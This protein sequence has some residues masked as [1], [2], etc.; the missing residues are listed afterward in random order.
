MDLVAVAAMTQDRI[1]AKD[2][3]L[4]WDHPADVEQYKRRV[5]NAPVVVGRKTFEDMYPDPPGAR[6]IVLTRSGTDA[7]LASTTVVGDVPGAL[8]VARDFGTD[9]TY[10]V[11]GG[12]VYVLFYPHYD[13]MVLTV[14]KDV[15]EATGAE[16]TRFPEWDRSKWVRYDRDESYS[17]LHIDFWR[18]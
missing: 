11:G 3:E 14:V 5:S 17:G 7:D 4:P 9:R 16:I 10:V 13:E 8:E 6:Q 1:I 18:R 2:G 12:Q 15:V